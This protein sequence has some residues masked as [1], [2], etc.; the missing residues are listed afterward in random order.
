[1]NTKLDW[2]LDLGMAPSEL[3]APEHVAKKIF[4]LADGKRGSGS[5]SRST[6]KA[7]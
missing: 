7:E 2:D 6:L 5:P 3:L 1:V 4:G